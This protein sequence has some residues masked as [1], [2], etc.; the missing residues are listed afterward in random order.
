MST[1]ESLN[2][3][4][5]LEK[6]IIKMKKGDFSTKEILASVYGA[7]RIGNALVELHN[8]GYMDCSGELPKLKYPDGVEKIENMTKADTALNNSNLKLIR[9]KSCRTHFSLGLWEAKAWIEKHFADNGSGAPIS[10]T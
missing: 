5:T 6:L 1:P 3:I 2:D 7:I 10:L 9:I 8:E 4:K